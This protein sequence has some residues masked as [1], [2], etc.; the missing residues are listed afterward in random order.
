MHNN[1]KRRRISVAHSSVIPIR[2]PAAMATRAQRREITQALRRRQLPDDPIEKAH[3]AGVR[4]YMA[5]KGNIVL[6]VHHRRTSVVLVSG[7]GVVTAD[8]SKYY[9]L[10]GVPP[11]TV[12]AYEQPLIHG[13]WVHNF[14]GGKT[15]VRRFDSK[16]KWSITEK[17]RIPVVLT[18]Y[19]AG[20]KAR[21]F[22]IDDSTTKTIDIPISFAAVAPDGTVRSEDDAALHAAARSQ[23]MAW[24]RTRSQ[25]NVKTGQL[26]SGSSDT[27]PDT[28]IDTQSTYQD[29][30]PDTES[31]AGADWWNAL[32]PFSQDWWVWTFGI[33]VVITMINA[34]DPAHHGRDS[35][36][37]M[38]LR[39]IVIPDGCW[40]AY[41]LHPGTFENTGIEKGG[42]I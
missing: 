31:N 19:R 25:L 2:T 40:R 28:L 38:P 33:D 20:K 32:E 34:Y 15:L 5:P 17:G 12:Y 26:T 13:K 37:D 9:N 36:M 6:R 3:A 24:I 27:F 21:A 35:V 7:A 18:R 22:W 41:D 29:T 30:V 4:P 1:P 11:P 39:S 42:A 16:G 8:G 10:E 14:G 23:V